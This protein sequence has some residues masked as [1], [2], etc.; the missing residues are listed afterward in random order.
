MA[1]ISRDSA[2]VAELVEFELKMADFQKK[3][4]QI[5]RL[6]YPNTAAFEAND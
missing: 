6:A 5:D 3:Q 2:D 1:R 4:W